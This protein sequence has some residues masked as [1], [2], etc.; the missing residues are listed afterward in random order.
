[1][2][3]IT[4]PENIIIRRARDNDL[5]EMARIHQ[6]SYPGI[7]LTLEQRMEHLHNDPCISF[8]DRWVC[9]KKNQLVGQFNL[10]NFNMYRDGETIPLGGIGGVA[11]AP[12]ARKEK[13]A[14][15]M[16]LRAVQI[17]EQNGTPLSVLYPF[18]HRFYRR[19]GWGMIGKVVRYK[20]DPS[21]LP[22]YSGK[23]NVIPVITYEDQEEV[24]ECYNH[25]GEQRNGLIERDEPRWF[26]KTFKNELCYAYRSTESGRIEGYILY[27]YRPLP[28]DTHFLV[29]DLDLREFV[30]TN[31]QSFRGLISFLSS[32]SDQVR[33]IVFHDQSGLPFEQIFSEPISVEGQRNFELGAETATIGTNLMGR[34]IQLR[35][36]LKMMGK[37]SNLQGKVTFKVTDD[38]NSNN[39]QPLTVNFDNGNTEFL[40]KDSADVVLSTDIATLSSIY[41]G[42]LRLQEAKWLGLVEI[43]GNGNSRFLDKLLAVSRPICLDYF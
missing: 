17:M 35:R 16:M 8:Q 33:A 27:K 2:E 32:Q 20:F 29:T 13:I 30:W 43:D 22:K 34:I 1:M 41:W 40:R 21:T 15:W 6:A 31:R 39:N 5:P 42:G 26:E 37:K 9:Q 19:L 38:L 18:L 24:M 11:V 10:Y 3:P 25:Y 23:E 4:L 12:E 7:D 36:V 14:Y 28:H